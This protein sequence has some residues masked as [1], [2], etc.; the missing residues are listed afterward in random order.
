MCSIPMAQRTI[1][2]IREDLRKQL[3]KSY[4]DAYDD[5][6][7]TWKTL[8]G[9][10]QVVSTVSGV[11]LAAA[12]AFARET[13][14]STCEKWLLG[15][16]VAFLALAVAGA[17]YALELATFPKPPHG[18]FAS[19]TAADILKQD[20]AA[21]REYAE[22]MAAFFASK[23]KATIDRLDALNADKANAV[24]IAQSLLSI[25]VVLIAIMTV[26]RI[27]SK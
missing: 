21:I 4:E 15:V 18:E 27:T 6:S 17:L 12:F 24:R 7:D 10:A 9:K 25:A 1:E 13:S 22:T 8:E 20:D 11:F 3:V 16:G 23:W 19:R 2:E 5:A 26:V 14:L